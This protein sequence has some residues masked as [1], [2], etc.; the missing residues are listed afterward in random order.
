PAGFRY[1]RNYDVFV[2]MGPIAGEEWLL[3][4]GNHQGFVGLGRLKPGVTIEAALAELRGIEADLSRTYPDTNAGINIGM[5]S[6][7]SRLVN[8]DRATLLVLFGAVGILLLI[9]CVNVANLL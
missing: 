5:D 7:K 8:Q 9:A 1:L 2:S 4:R 3:D 6:L